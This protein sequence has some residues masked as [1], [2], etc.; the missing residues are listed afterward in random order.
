MGHFHKRNVVA[1]A[2]A[3]ISFYKRRLTAYFGSNKL[4]SIAILL[5]HRM[6]LLSDWKHFAH[7]WAYCRLVIL[8]CTTYV[9]CAHIFTGRTQFSNLHVHSS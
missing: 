8:S 7:A 3:M 9:E 5:H 4:I 6:E 1:K 2:H